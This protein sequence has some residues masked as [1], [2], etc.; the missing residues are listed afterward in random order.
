MI[1]GSG[2]F[3]LAHDKKW[4]RPLLRV[5]RAND[6]GAVSPRAVG[7]HLARLNYNVHLATTD[8]SVGPRC[9]VAWRFR[10]G[11]AHNVG[12]GHQFY[13]G[14]DRDAS[15][16]TLPIIANG[17]DVSALM[18][19]IMPYMTKRLRAMR[20]GQSIPELNEDEMNADVARLPDK[21]DED[22]R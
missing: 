2:A 8:G 7:D 22:L 3:Y 4:I 1:G 17:M 11:G 14:T 5:V 9:T 13:T 21:P 19:T 12:G 18:E 20:T 6:R 16:P 10:K 15:T